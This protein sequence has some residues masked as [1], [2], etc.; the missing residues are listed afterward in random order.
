MAMFPAMSR[1]QVMI[2]V[3][4]G[5]GMT[6]MSSDDASNTTE[7]KGGPISADSL[8]ALKKFVASKKPLVMIDEKLSTA[9]AFA[10]LKK[11]QIA[12]VKLA[13]PTDGDLK[14]YGDKA[15]NGIL[16][17]TTGS[18]GAKK[19]GDPNMRTITLPDGRTIQVHIQGAGGTGAGTI[20]IS[21]GGR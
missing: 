14:Y 8:V 19:E 21:P 7:K 12:G 2:A 4:S 20:V 9:K 5:G 1:A 17:V 6:I 13:D 11:E 16:S 18:T 10:E 3:P 15:K